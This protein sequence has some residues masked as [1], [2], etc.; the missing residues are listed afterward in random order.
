MKTG[1]MTRPITPKPAQAVSRLTLTDY[2]N[3]ER[4]R[5]EPPS[6]LI[7]LVGA[8]GAGKTNLLE[9]ISL[10]APGRGLRGAEFSSLGRRQAN[11]AD[12]QAWAVSA[13]VV[14]PLGECQLG[15]AWSASAEVGG[16][17][18][19]AILIDGQLQKSSGNLAN[20]LRIVWLTPQL[21]RLFSGPTSERRRYLDRMVLLFDAAH[22]SRINA[23]EKLMRERNALLQQTRI[24]QQW[25]TSLEKQ[26]AESA[27]AISAARLQA[28][29]NLGRYLD[30]ENLP[31]PFPWSSLSVMGEIETLVTTL[32]ALAA[33]DH[34]R[35]LL[36]EGRSQ[37]RAA[38]RTLA[39]P[40][41][42]DLKVQHGPKGIAAAEGSTGEQKAL[43]IGLALAQAQAIRSVAGAAPVMLL[44]EIAA[45]LDKARRE[46]LFGLLQDL[47][48]QVW[49]TG[50]EPELF[51]GAHGSGMVYHVEN[52]SLRES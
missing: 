33:E 44:D 50:T 1:Q 42:S 12:G 51:H 5:L 52:G 48:L 39:G 41:R 8:N 18:S 43:L 16:P 20:L 7:A 2:R 15:S 46:A 36:R 31:G 3:Y 34:Y 13:R 40:H 26:M 9:A 29:T 35:N 37:D 38:G 21:D 47:R 28:V 6:G 4:L 32:P 14:G 11:V 27:I 30:D 22:G 25:A 10:L 23:F 17:S 19:R 49:M 24:D 45:H